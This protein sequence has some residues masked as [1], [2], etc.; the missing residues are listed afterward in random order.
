MTYILLNS[1]VESPPGSI[2]GAGQGRGGGGTH[3]IPSPSSARYQQSSIL[4]HPSPHKPLSP[5]PWT[6]QA[7][8]T[9]NKAGS[10]SSREL[11]TQQK[12]SLSHG[13]DRCP[14]APGPLDAVKSLGPAC[15]HTNY[16]YPTPSWGKVGRRKKTYR[17]VCGLWREQSCNSPCLL[18][19]QRS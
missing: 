5:V 1:S 8:F 9:W 15:M 7:A 2:A 18:G 10:I 13:S 3:S 4:K 19:T 16:T 11:R 17:E 6:A 12:Q 14:Q